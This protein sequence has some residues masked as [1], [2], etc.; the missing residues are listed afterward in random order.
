MVRKR[1]EELLGRL[2]QGESLQSLADADALTVVSSGLV[3]RNDRVLPPALL[4]RLFK[5]P[6]PT[7]DDSQYDGTVL[8]NGDYAIIALG[9]V[10]DGVLEQD[11]KENENAL[12]NLQ[13]RS[14]GT[15]YFNHFIENQ[16]KNAEI[17]I[18]RQEQQ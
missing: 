14:R 9:A 1:G 17:V 11:D 13:E 16:R 18:T 7:G 5:M 2:K 3:S 4:Q 8:A 12:K 15:A 6:R 10:K